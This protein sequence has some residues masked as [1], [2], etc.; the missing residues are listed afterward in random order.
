ME[1][2]LGV[3]GPPRPRNPVI[4]DPKARSPTYSARASL[5]ILGALNNM[6]HPDCPL[7]VLQGASQLPGGAGSV[8][9]P[10]SQRT[11]LQVSLLAALEQKVLVP[12]LQ[13]GPMQS[14]EVKSESCTMWRGVLTSNGK[15]WEGWEWLLRPGRARGL[16]LAPTPEEVI[17]AEYFSFQDQP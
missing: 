4:P 6:E 15:F 5:N 17:S 2:T 12:I 9:H 8:S 14:R 1:N 16:S 3:T 11:N 7:L 13:R 10:F